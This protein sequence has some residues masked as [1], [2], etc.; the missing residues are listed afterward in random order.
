MSSTEAH[1]TSR[2]SSKNPDESSSTPDDK[3]PKRG[4][5]WQSLSIIVFR[6]EPL[7]AYQFRH[8]GLLIDHQNQDGKVTR[9][10]FLHITGSAR[11][12]EREE[13]VDQNPEDDD[14]FIARLHVATIPATGSFDRRLRNTI[15]ATPVNNTDYD[16]GPQ[17]WVGD[18]LNWCAAVELLSQS[19]VDAG[20]DQMTDILLEAPDQA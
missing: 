13:R 9:K 6:A 17:N 19:D 10:N 11:I 4:Q 14:L 16:W 12:F 3:K 5:R 8:A 15:W 18:A 2:N 7:D 1:S 20:I